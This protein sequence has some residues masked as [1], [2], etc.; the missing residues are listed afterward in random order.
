M[1]DMLS[2]FRENFLLSSLT[3]EELTQ[4]L[5]EAIA[6]EFQAGDVLLHEGDEGHSMLLLN[7]GEVQVRRGHRLLA[8]LKD[9]TV[10]GELALLD[11]APR[12]ATVV[13]ITNGTLYEFHRDQLWDMVRRGESAAIKTLQKLTMLMCHRLH[14]VNEMIQQEAVTP[15]GNVWTRLWQ[16]LF[17]RKVE[18]S[19][20]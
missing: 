19:T 1:S 16:R 18:G 15:S 13:A 17:P 10:I 14:D 5:S 7:R 2:Y 3:E 12:T 8:R 11:P 9:S 4:L 20:S 6:R